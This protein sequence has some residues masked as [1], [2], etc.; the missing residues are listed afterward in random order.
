MRLFA[1]NKYIFP[2][3]VSFL[4]QTGKFYFHRRFVMTS[5]DVMSAEES[6]VLLPLKNR[7][8]SQPVA[9]ALFLCNGD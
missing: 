9:W 6:T 3:E 5:V 2:K 8:Y 7:Q 1:S 4:V